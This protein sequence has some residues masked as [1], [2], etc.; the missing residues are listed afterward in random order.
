MQLSPAAARRCQW[1]GGGDLDSEGGAVE[2][3][4]PAAAEALVGK[5]KAAEQ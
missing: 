3:E 1:A 5:G 2:P 4:C